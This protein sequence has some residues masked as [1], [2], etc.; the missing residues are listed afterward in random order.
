MKKNKKINSLAFAFAAAALQALAEHVL[1]RARPAARKAVEALDDLGRV[2]RPAAPT[3]SD[4]AGAGRAHS[5]R[6]TTPT[7]WTTTTS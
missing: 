6:P 2:G 3:S 4:S 5:M 1:G 7:P